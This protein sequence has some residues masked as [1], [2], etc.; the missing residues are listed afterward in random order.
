MEKYKVLSENKTPLDARFDIDGNC[1]VLNSRGGA[2]GKLNGTNPDYTIALKTILERVVSSSRL[3]LVDAYVDSSA[4]QNLDIS[5]RRILQSDELTVSASEQLALMQKRMRVVGQSPHKKIKG[6]NSSKKIRLVFDQPLSR[7]VI[8]NVLIAVPFYD[9]KLSARQLSRVKAD[10]LY[11]AV[12]RLEQGFNEHG[13]A[14]STKYDLISDNNVRLD[15]K[16]VFGV[17]AHEALGHYVGPEDFTAG[18][19]SVSFRIL[20]ECGFNI[21]LKGQTPIIEPIPIDPDDEEWAEG[22]KYRATH[23]RKERGRNLSKAK[24]ASFKSKNNGILYCE[25]C[26]LIPHEV[27]SSKHAEACIEVH[28]SKVTVKEMN[29]NHRTKLEDLQCLCANCHRIVHREMSNSI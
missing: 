4:V 15:P 19:S 2:V 14:K 5:A 7:E 12:E 17:A 11:R 25:R 21:V 23:L 9:S 27:F 8:S 10:H 1:I 20:R 16:A 3:R 24:K 22:N 18:D 26:G 29:E 28:H 6:G 13:F